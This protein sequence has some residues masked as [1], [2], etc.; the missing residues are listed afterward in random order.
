MSLERNLAMPR[1]LK[2]TDVVLRVLKTT[3]CGT[4]IHILKGNVPSC[5]TATRLGHEGIGEVMETGGN[6]R[7]R[8][9]ER[10]RERE[11]ERERE[12]KVRE[13]PKK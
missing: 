12:G 7:E 5:Q 11:R 3:I 2:R 4:D 10:G 1:V 8:E 6:E 9:R 13:R